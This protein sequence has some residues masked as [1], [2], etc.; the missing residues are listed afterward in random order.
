M[1]QPSHPDHPK[2][3]PDDLTSSKDSIVTLE[4]WA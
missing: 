3:E 4:Y 1:R 2:P